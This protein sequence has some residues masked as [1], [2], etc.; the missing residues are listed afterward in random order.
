MAKVPVHDADTE[1]RPEEK[2]IIARTV[3][4]LHVFRARDGSGQQP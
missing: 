4:R 2:Q 1:I 3:R